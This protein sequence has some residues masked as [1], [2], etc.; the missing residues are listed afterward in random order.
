[1]AKKHGRVH[2]ANMV[3]DITY[4]YSFTE[5]AFNYQLD[6]FKRGGKDRDY[7]TM[8]VQDKSDMD[9]AFFIPAPEWVSKPF[10][11]ST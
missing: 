11:L 5:V 9:N 2:V 8:Y 1:V 6:N 7:I 10:I 4:R 3:H